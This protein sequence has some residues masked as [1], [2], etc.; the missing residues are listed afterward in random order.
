[1]ED[2]LKDLL[3]VGWRV[4]TILPLLLVI[5]LFMGKRAVGELPVFDFLVIITLAS[6]VG[7]DIA[8]PNINHLPTI[9][10][11]IVIALLQKTV[12][13]LKIASQKVD[14]AV[15][16]EATI[17][18]QDGIFLNQN[19]KKIGYTVS[20]ILEMLRNNEIFDI[21]EVETAIIEANGELSVLKAK[22]SPLPISFPVVLE[23]KIMED[24][25][26]ALHVDKEWLIKKLHESNIE[27]L[28]DV[29]FASINRQK[30]LHISKFNQDPLFVP[31]I[32]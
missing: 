20:N 7:A 17:V 21:R 18:I 27:Q 9:F 11:I 4:L 16:F 23:G 8:D 29:F 5:T 30:D 14:Q 15:T 12:A 25:L 2:L 32:K 3:L 13:H 6:V 26:P 22:S 24:V 28:E 31:P 1:M 19:L 10:A